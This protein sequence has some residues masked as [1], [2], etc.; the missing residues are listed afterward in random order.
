M[1]SGKGCGNAQTTKMCIRDSLL[2]DDKHT[3]AMIEVNAETDFVAKNEMCIRDSI[4]SPSCA[5]AK[6]R[7]TAAVITDFPPRLGPVMTNSI[8][9]ESRC[10]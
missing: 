10:V 5:I 2:S 3:A 8:P 9:S 4:G 7:P 6:A 1:L